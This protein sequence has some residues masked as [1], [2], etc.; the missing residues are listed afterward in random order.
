MASE[1]SNIF[2]PTFPSYCLSL[3][4]NTIC[5]A[6][7][8]PLFNTHTQSKRLTCFHHNHSKALPTQISRVSIC[9]YLIS[10]LNVEYSNTHLSALKSAQTASQAKARFSTIKM[11]QSPRPTSEPD[12]ME[13]Y[14]RIPRTYTE[15]G[16]IGPW[17]FVESFITPTN[18]HDETC[19]ICASKFQDPV[20]LIHDGYP[21]RKH[22]F[23]HDC[24]QD[25]WLVPCPDIKYRLV[26]GHTSCPICRYEIIDCAK[27]PTGCRD[28]ENVQML[29]RTAKALRQIFGLDE[30]ILEGKVDINQAT[31]H[32]FMLGL[33][34]Y[35]HD[36]PPSSRTMCQDLEVFLFGYEQELHDLEYLNTKQMTWLTRDIQLVL[37]AAKKFGWQLDRA[38]AAKKPQLNSAEATKKPQDW[39]MKRAIEFGATTMTAMMAMSDE[40]VKAIAK[41]K[42]ETATRRRN[43]LA[44]RNRT[45]SK[46]ATS[47]AENS[48]SRSK[49]KPR[50]IDCIIKSQK[51]KKRATMR[52]GGRVGQ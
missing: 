46:A 34:G 3:H 17:E 41:T 11:S 20:N 44:T 35:F 10:D 47:T 26:V 19:P 45:R 27:K 1:V 51:Q 40:N 2:S 33:D 28:W 23:C 38:E 49:P 39:A 15:V 52:K 4:Q 9:L 25:W 7:N 30:E 14:Y 48:T 43:A 5:K 50:Q 37:A 29:D 36:T 32:R 31:L 12:A 6:S 21:D 16:L 24:I 42:E 13:A 18:D 8:N 22:T